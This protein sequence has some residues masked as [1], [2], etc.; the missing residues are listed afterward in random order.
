MQDMQKTKKIELEHKKLITEYNAILIALATVTIGMTGLAYTI[1]N[2]ILL[3]LFNLT[4]TFPI[5]NAEKERK[6]EE[7]NKKAQE[8][9]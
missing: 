3:S 4:I 9:E 8:I 2:N 7:L 6:S 1:T 5:L